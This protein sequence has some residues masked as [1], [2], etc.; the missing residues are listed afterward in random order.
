MTGSFLD[1]VWPGE[2]PG[3]SSCAGIRSSRDA[4]LEELNVHGGFQQTDVATERNM[5]SFRERN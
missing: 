5:F 1:G 4:G 3:S 2:I